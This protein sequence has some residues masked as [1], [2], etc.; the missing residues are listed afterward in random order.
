MVMLTGDE[1]DSGDPVALSRGDMVA[2]AKRSDLAL[3]FENG[4]SNI[5]TV[6]RR[7]SS[8][9]TLEVTA[10]TGHSSAIF[11]GMG[12]GAIFEAARILDQFYETLIANGVDVQ[13]PVDEGW[14]GCF[15]TLE[16]P[17]KYRYFFVT[18]GVTNARTAP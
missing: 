1:E 6:A 13:P 12:S 7:G 17:D 4:G 10:R 15:V 9:W 14:G 2:A 18:W 3:S 16:D 8:D 5:A 11:K